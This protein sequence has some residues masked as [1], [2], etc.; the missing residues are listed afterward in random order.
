[1]FGST[2]VGNAHTDGPVAGND[3]RLDFPPILPAL[4]QYAQDQGV[5]PDPA[6]V[7]LPATPREGNLLVLA[8]C[9]RENTST[10]LTPAGWQ[11]G[12]EFDGP[13]FDGGDAVFFYRVA[14]AAEPRTVQV[15]KQGANYHG[16]C[17]AEFSGVAVLDNSAFADD[18]GHAVSMAAGPLTTAIGSPM[19]VIA[20][21]NQSARSALPMSGPGTQLGAIQVFSS[22]PAWCW[23]FTATVTSSGSASASAGSDDDEGYGW[24]MMSFV[25]V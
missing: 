7:T 1:M 20:G 8:F 11:R 3:P 4:V 22:G 24:G 23:G 2:L 5:Q 14:G 13:A 12:P 16:I 21:F 15:V 17:L 10:G 9:T 19:L 6:I 25:Q 18:V